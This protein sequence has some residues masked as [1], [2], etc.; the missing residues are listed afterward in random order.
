VS[1]RKVSLADLTNDEAQPAPPPV[2]KKEPEQTPRPTPRRA[3][4]GA[5]AGS[6]LDS[7]TLH[8]LE[9]WAA[10]K[11]D[12]VG[13]ARTRAII[14]NHADQ[15]RFSAEIAARL[16]KFVNMYEAAEAAEVPAPSKPSKKQRSRSTGQ[17]S[18]TRKA[19][20]SPPASPPA[21]PAAKPANA[22]PPPPVD[23]EEDEEEA[24]VVLRLIAGI[25]N[26]GAGVKWRNHKDG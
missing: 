16:L 12:R 15:G 14:H 6:E 7:S 25:Q 21:A 20:S 1:I 9:D 18:S 22:S 5:T 23:P 24:S 26:A 17:A 4:N 19:A 13:A 10:N 3:D 2:V 11:V 8:R